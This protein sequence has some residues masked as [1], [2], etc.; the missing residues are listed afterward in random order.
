[1]KDKP[2][3]WD[4]E[5]EAL[6]WIEWFDTGNSD[7]PTRHY[8]PPAKPPAKPPAAKAPDTHKALAHYRHLGLVCRT[9]L[10]ENCELCDFSHG[11]QI[12]PYSDGPCILMRLYDMAHA[13]HE[14]ESNDESGALIE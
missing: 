9:D 8:L 11:C 4:D 7:I 12:E 13:A 14:C 2:V 3:Y 10:P 5:R 1:M 6:Y